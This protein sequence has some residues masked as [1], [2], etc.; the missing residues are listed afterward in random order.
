MA[1]QS[2]RLGRTVLSVAEGLFMPDMTVPRNVGQRK[3]VT[4][5]TALLD[6]KRLIMPNIIA[7]HLSRIDL[8]PD[9]HGASREDKKAIFAW[10][11]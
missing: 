1:D 11:K 6:K 4:Q 5:P 3:V 7:L 2:G 10:R 9:A 8:C